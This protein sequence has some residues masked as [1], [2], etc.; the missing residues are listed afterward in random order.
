MLPLTQYLENSISDYVGDE[1]WG[2]TGVDTESFRVTVSS[3]D[4]VR[5]TF[6]VESS[7]EDCILTSTIY[8]QS[9]F[10]QVKKTFKEEYI[11]G[12]EEDDDVEKL[13][14]AFNGNE[15]EFVEMLVNTDSICEIAHE[16]LVPHL[17]DIAEKFLNLYTRQ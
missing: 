16:K 12:V 2:Q 1:L 17:H 10:E 4:K 8:L 5:N 7:F 9:F 3:V 13:R 6:V 11:D 15:W 14:N